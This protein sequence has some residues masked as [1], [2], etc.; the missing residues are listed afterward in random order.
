VCVTVNILKSSH[1]CN[2]D[3]LVVCVY[4]FCVFLYTFLF[5]FTCVCVC[6]CVFVCVYRA[7]CCTQHNGGST[8]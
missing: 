7:P 3:M 5:T 8:S 1:S 4:L 2:V 6:V